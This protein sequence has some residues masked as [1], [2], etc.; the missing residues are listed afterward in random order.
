MTI[1]SLMLLFEILHQCACGGINSQDL[2]KRAGLGKG[3][4]ANKK[5]R[6]ALRSGM[7]NDEGS[8]DDE[9]D[10]EGSYFS[11]IEF[12]EDDIKLV[13]PESSIKEEEEEYYDEESEGEEVDID[14]EKDPESLKRKATLKKKL[15]GKGIEED[16]L[17]DPTPDPN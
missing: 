4:A 5:K 17:V 11:E 14:L 10:S 12:P 2:G 7:G 6:R 3:K 8:Y 16:E 9:Y 13:T 15:K 1:I